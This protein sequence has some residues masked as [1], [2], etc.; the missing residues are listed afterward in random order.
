M[1]P[2]LSLPRIAAHLPFTYTG[3]DFYALCSDAMLKAVTRQ[4]T[5]VDSKIAAIN[6]S[7]SQR[8]GGQEK[9][10]PIT[11]AYF[12]DHF[13]SKEDIAVLVTEE[14]FLAANRELIPSVS[15]KELEHYKRVREQFESID[16][17]AKGT[18][19]DATATNGTNGTVTKAAQSGV[20][21]WQVSHR[22]KT[23]GNGH[24][25]RP[26]S[27]GKDRGK[28]KG[29]ASLEDLDEED[30]YGE[31]EEDGVRTMGATAG[32]NGKAN[33]GGFVEQGVEDDEGLY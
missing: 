20:P 22:P 30:G 31:A 12:F 23:N 19:P 17:K 13:A 24:T 16:D 4:A 6:A 32:L 7:R 9:E 15:A 29:R 14:D 1:S 18:A 26:R 2:T 28:G 27:R 33:G 8:T 3:A 10:L 25:G 11:T 21:D 5:A